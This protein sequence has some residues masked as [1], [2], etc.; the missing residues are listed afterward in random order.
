MASR[1]ASRA[2]KTIPKPKE[3]KDFISIRRQVLTL[4]PLTITSGFLPQAIQDSNESRSD[5]L[6]S[7]KSCYASLCNVLCIGAKR[8]LQ[9]FFSMYCT[10]CIYAYKTFQNEL[11]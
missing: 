3:Y 11:T 2:Y 9:R 1:A 6:L 8:L 7:K 4:T 10:V 5:N